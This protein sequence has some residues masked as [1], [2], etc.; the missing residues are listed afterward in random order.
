[1]NRSITILAVVSIVA[2]VG[3]L[4]FSTNVTPVDAQQASTAQTRRS[5]TAQ[6][7][8]SRGAFQYATLATRVTE[9]ADDSRITYEVTWN[10][11]DDLVVVTSRVSLEDA[12]R[13]LIN[14][15]RGS[16]GRLTLL[17][18]LLNHFGDEGWELIETQNNGSFNT[19]LFIRRR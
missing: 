18:S 19:R 3:S 5:N 12:Y 2:I 9:D 16:I 6:A 1:M 11:D 13:R 17:S 8:Q 10:N 15:R 7:Q 4:V 14:R